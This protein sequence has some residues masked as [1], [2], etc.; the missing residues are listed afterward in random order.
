MSELKMSGSR[1]KHVEK[2]GGGLQMCGIR[3]EWVGARFSITH[4]KKQ[5]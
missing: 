1:L 2:D 5:F 4:V 3:W